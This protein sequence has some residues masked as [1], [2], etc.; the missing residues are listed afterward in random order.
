MEI[1]KAH[2]FNVIYQVTLE[3]HERYNIGTY[4]EKKLHIILKRYFEN[5]TLYHEIPTNGFIADINR[6]G[7][8]TEIETSGF[9]GL[10]QK[11]AAYL[12]EY[13][14]NLVYPIAGIKYISWIAPE[15]NSISKRRRSSK[16]ANIYDVLFE[17]VRILPYVNNKNLT[18]IAA[19][20]EIDEYRLLNGWSTDRKKGS[21]RYE[22]V[23]TDFL[24]IIEL[25]TD[26]DYRRYIP[27]SCKPE[28][29]IVEFAK[30]AKILRNRAYAVVKVFEK[31]GIVKMIE[32][33]GRTHV[34]RICE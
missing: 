32:K 22:R 15:S 7:C 27:D 3:Q 11:L 29:T 19:I 18:V 28:F 25:S 17:M 1:N 24:D 12:P 6:D 23:P 13:K 5:D 4:K 20:L 31:R 21:S 10:R 8:I 26:N 9:S 33:R 34:Y 14:V 16:K 2:F 30:A